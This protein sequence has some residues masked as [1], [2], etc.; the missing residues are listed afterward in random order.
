VALAFLLVFS[1]EARKGEGYTATDERYS[2]PT[3][4][5][6]SDITTRSRYIL[7]GDSSVWAYDKKTGEVLSKIRIG[8]ARPT[9]PTPTLYPGA[10]TTAEEWEGLGR[11]LDVS[12]LTTDGLDVVETFFRDRLT[13]EGLTPIVHRTPD[14][15]TSVVTATDPK[16][17][18]EVRILLIARESGSGTVIGYTETSVE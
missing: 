8:M 2:S 6:P 9:P 4:T 15:K 13:K 16:T 3:V 18:R 7:A 11:K 1:A 12:Q 17:K 14:N 10:E 5:S